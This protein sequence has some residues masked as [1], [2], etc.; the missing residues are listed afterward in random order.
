MERC[1]TYAPLDVRFDEWVICRFDTELPTRIRRAT[2]DRRRNRFRH[3][4]R[5]EP[6]NVVA[7]RNTHG[8]QTVEPAGLENKNPR[9]ARLERRAA[10]KIHGLRSAERIAD[11]PPRRHNLLR[12]LWARHAHVEVALEDLR[13]LATHL[14]DRRSGP[15]LGRQETFG[16]K[17]GKILRRQRRVG[18]VVRHVGSEPRPV[19]RSDRRE[20]AEGRPDGVAVAVHAITTYRCA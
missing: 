17:C 3:V 16:R 10:A 18:S 20:G 14:G 4:L 9:V 15:E 2:I 19:R 13:A 11:L 5:G 12:R 6:N 8:R 1:A 7:Q